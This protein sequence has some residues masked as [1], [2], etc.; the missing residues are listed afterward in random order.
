MIKRFSRR[1][2]LQMHASDDVELVVQDAGPVV[3]GIPALRPDRA[4]RGLPDVELET[5]LDDLRRSGL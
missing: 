3:P 1:I 2:S 5:C 4:G